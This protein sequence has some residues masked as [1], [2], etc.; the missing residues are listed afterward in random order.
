MWVQLF[1]KKIDNSVL[2][3]HLKEAQL[4]TIGTSWGPIWADIPDVAATL[5]NQAK[6]MADNGAEGIEKAV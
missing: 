1:P 5:N 6:A 4:V 2:A 3:K